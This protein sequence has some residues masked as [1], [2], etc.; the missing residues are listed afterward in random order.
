[1]HEGRQGD[2]K[3]VRLSLVGTT[4]VARARKVLNTLSSFVSVISVCDRQRGFLDLRSCPPQEKGPLCVPPHLL[5]PQHPS[6]TSLFFILPF[7][8]TPCSPSPHLSRINPRF[9][10]LIF[11][12][13]A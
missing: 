4:D 3:E 1:M 2:V 6:S 9:L 7:L 12:L 11:S 13:S 5:V 8:T 10:L